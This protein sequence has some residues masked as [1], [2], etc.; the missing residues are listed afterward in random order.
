MKKV[1]VGLVGIGWICNAVHVEGYKEV[2]ECEISAICDIDE[3]KLKKVGDELGIPENRRFTDYKELI[4][5]E[6]V[7]VVDI[8]TWNSVHCEIAKATALA[9]KAFSVEKPVGMNY[10]EALDLAKTAEEQGVES[11]VTLSWRYRPYTR[12]VKHLISSGK[13]GKL[14]HIYVRCIKDSGLWKGRKREWRFDKSRGGSGVLGD[15]G[16][17][18]VDI[19]RFWGQEFKDIY[20]KTGIFIK[21]RPS[22]EDGT[23]LPVDTDDWCNMMASLESDASCTIQLTRCATTVANLMQFEVYGEKGK[24]VYT[25]LDD[26]QTI[27]FVD[28]ETN[29]KEMLTPPPEFDAVQSKSF[30]NLVNG[31]EDEFTAKIIQGLECQA[32]LDAAIISSEENRVVTIAEIKGENK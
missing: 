17:H 13:V 4:A 30:I 6:D 18:M 31:I 2:E 22:E 27:E 25:F 9:G 10:A 28:A 32:V 12:Y 20:C 16:S 14:Y 24:L 29:E 23:I 19:V 7:D 1:R 5:C 26:D 8:A 15:L 11:F 21:E 3:A